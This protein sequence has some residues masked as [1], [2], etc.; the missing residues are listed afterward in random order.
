MDFFFFQKQAQ[1]I[2]EVIVGMK[3]GMI[4]GSPVMEPI[5]PT[6]GKNTEH[7]KLTESTFQ[8]LRIGALVKWEKN[9]NLKTRK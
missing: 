2:F 3:V 1:I 4:C 5:S 8:A 6:I 7:K 9:T